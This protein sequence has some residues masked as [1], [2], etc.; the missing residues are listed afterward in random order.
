MSIEPFDW[1]NRFFGGN[2]PFGRRNTIFE[3]FEEMKK[4]MEREIEENLRDIEEKAPKDL[5]KEYVAE[6]GARVKEIGPLIYGATT[7]IGAKVSLL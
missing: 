3:G 2:W 6:D 5:I 7:T 4:D 1:F